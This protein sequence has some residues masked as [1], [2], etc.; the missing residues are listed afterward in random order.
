MA[1]KG[2]WEKAA[3]DLRE[4]G[5]V[6]QRIHKRALTQTQE[7]ILRRFFDLFSFGPHT[8]G[9]AASFRRALNEIKPAQLQQGIRAAILWPLPLTIGAAL[10][11][12]NYANFWRF[13]HAYVQLATPYSALR[14]LFSKTFFDAGLQLVKARMKGVATE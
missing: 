3:L 4:A 12:R 5:D 8:F 1:R 14:S 11:H 2:L 10:L 13:L 6:A 9:A 7:A